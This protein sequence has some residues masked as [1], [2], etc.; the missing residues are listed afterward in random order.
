MC[1]TSIPAKVLLADAKLLKLKRYI[2][3]SNC[4]INPED[5]FYAAPRKL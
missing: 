5:F 3:A 4:F 2:A 1:T